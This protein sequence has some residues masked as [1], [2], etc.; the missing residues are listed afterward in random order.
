MRSGLSGEAILDNPPSSRLAT[1]TLL[2]PI[3]TL[4]LPPAGLPPP[5][6]RW[7][8]EGAVTESADRIEGRLAGTDGPLTLPV[9]LPGMVDVLTLV[10]LWEA[11][12]GEWSSLTG[13]SSLRAA[14]DFRDDRSEPWSKL[15]KVEWAS[16]L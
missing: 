11:A 4:L 2:L 8:T 3:P 5:A 7:P 6:P 10:M 16:W 12:G 9:L 1:P 13:L 15:S 14:P